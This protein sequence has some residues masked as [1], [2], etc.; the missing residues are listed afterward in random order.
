M[1]NQLY[2]LLNLPTKFNS[3]IAGKIDQKIRVDDSV[4]RESKRDGGQIVIIQAANQTFVNQINEHSVKAL[5]YL[6][7][8]EQNYFVQSGLE[9]SL[10]KCMM[11]GEPWPALE[12]RIK[13]MYFKM[14]MDNHKTLK[15]AAKQIGVARTTISMHLDRCRKENLIDYENKIDEGGTE[16][17]D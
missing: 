2:D 5:K 10:K 8:L 14:A 1:R 13:A 17:T 11:A 15:E 7:Q 9:A 4:L 3:Q 12:K 16:P 6:D